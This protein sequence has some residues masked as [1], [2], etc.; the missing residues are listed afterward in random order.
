MS[1]I[2]QIHC[3]CS[4]H[5]SRSP[6]AAVNHRCGTTRCRTSCASNSD[7]A[8]A[9]ALVLS[10]QK[11]DPGADGAGD[12]PRCSTPAL[13]PRAPARQRRR[14]ALRRRGARRQ[15]PPRFARAL[16]PIDSAP[17]VAQV[18]D[19]WRAIQRVEIEPG[20][21]RARRALVV[22]TQRSALAPSGVGLLAGLAGALVVQRLR[23]PLEQTVAGALISAR[24]IIERAE[25]AVPS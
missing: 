16:L 21:L 5:C 22:A 19:G 6:A 17:G 15:V 4:E 8:T 13:P 10:Q 24:R 7:N 11:G 25:P 12:E 9:L 18:S 14:G 1:L 20:V 23:G 2:R 3:C